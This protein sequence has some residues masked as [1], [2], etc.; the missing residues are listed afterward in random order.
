MFARSKSSAGTGSADNLA[1]GRP[2]PT[3][4]PSGS[5]QSLSPPPS[6]Q[7]SL[8]GRSKS[9][10][11]IS[12]SKSRDPNATP[13]SSS[14]SA[15]SRSKSRDARLASK[16]SS[17]ASLGSP[18]SR[19]KS[20]LP[21]NSAPGSVSPS[22]AQLQRSKSP[23]SSSPSLLQS[24]SPSSP[25]LAQG[26]SGSRGATGRSNIP[27]PV[28]PTQPQQYQSQ[29]W[30]NPYTTDIMKEVV[31][32]TSR[33]TFIVKCPSDATVSW[34]LQAATDLMAGSGANAGGR[35]PLVAART[36]DGTVAR[37]EEKIFS[38]CRE[39]KI[40]FAITADEVCN[41]P[42]AFQTAFS[43]TSGPTKSTS[44]LSSQKPLPSSTALDGSIQS[45]DGTDAGG[46]PRRRRRTIVRA[47]EMA[48]FAPAPAVPSVPDAKTRTTVER[49]SM[50]PDGAVKGV[51]DREKMA[52]MSLQ[53]KMDLDGV[54]NDLDSWVAG[55]VF[56]YNV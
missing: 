44:S 24:K 22:L 54:M 26:R 50:S 47:G 38:V 55:E 28:P 14:T 5:S 10:A 7:S 8:A 48:S 18:G 46:Q 3:S 41:I 31:V 15:M 33:G 4:P 40:L 39:N 27:L 53:R 21:P 30:A 12:R 16:S 1:R 9:S 51:M 11:A 45:L 34:A 36:A 42:P 2:S 19:V 49:R 56:E 20:P 17:A 35:N 43:H 32:V 37:D 52:R 6:P 29:Q 25:S 13:P 23:N